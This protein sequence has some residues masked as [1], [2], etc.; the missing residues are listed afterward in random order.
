MI[1]NPNYK[2][3]TGEVLANN[4]KNLLGSYFA[5]GSLDDSLLYKPMKSCLDRI[6]MKVHPHK[7]VVIPVV[8]KMAK[9]PDDFFK[10]VYMVGCGSFEMKDAINHRIVEREIIQIPY[11]EVKERYCEDKCGDLYEMVHEFD[12]ITLKY[13][14]FF[15]VQV[16]GS[17]TKCVEEFL[18][19]E[20]NNQVSIQNNMIYANFSGYIYLEY[21]SSLENCEG[22]LLVLDYTQITDWIETCMMIECLEKLYLNGDADVIQRLQYL[23]SKRQ[24]KEGV[25]RSFWKMNEVQDFYD[26]RRVLKNRFSMYKNAVKP[27]YS[28]QYN[29]TINIR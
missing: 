19:H 3:I 4:V 26:V 24:M 25:A 1:N 13:T 15:P 23:E 18:H 28:N 11:G 6:G 20:A 8:D 2:Y 22:D 10:V 12:E 5:Q 9:L 16:T 21:L 14:D 7:T 17:N 29:T 27:Y